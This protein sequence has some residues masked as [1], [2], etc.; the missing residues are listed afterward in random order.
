M[1]MFDIPS[2]ILYQI[3]KNPDKIPENIQIECA[4]RHIDPCAWDVK[5][6][7]KLEF[8]LLEWTKSK[9]WLIKNINT[10]VSASGNDILWE[11]EFEGIEKEHKP[12]PPFININLEYKTFNVKVEENLASPF[13]K[14]Q[15]EAFRNN[16]K[17]LN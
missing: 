6:A 13:I 11:L 7:A 5:N 17:N 1:N 16:L 8:E 9:L 10:S 4:L 2:E 15:I 3:G 14:K 12:K